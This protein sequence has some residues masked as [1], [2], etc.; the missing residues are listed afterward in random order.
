MGR[1]ATLIRC[2]RDDCV[3]TPSTFPNR[4][5]LSI[6]LIPVIRSQRIVRMM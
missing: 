3:P 2:P 1:I 6:E 5:L 4:V